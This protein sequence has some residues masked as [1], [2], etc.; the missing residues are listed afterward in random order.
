MPRTNHDTVADVDNEIDFLLRTEGLRAATEALISTC[1]DASAPAQARAAAGRTIFE[2]TGR[3]KKEPPGPEKELH[4][5]S[6]AELRERYETEKR[7]LAAFD[8]L[9]AEADEAE[10]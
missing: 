6:A 9:V 1:K 7:K 10:D 4:E 5:L 3:L 8:A 2:A